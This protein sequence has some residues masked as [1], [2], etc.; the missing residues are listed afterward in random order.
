MRSGYKGSGVVIAS[1][2]NNTS[3]HGGNG[4]DIMK[5]IAPEADILYG[6]D[7]TR[8]IPVQNNQD[9]DV[10][11]YYDE[12]D[13]YTTARFSNDDYP[14]KVE[15][16][17]ELYNQ[18]VFLVCA[19]GNDGTEEARKLSQYKHWT[20]VGACIL[21]D[22]KPKRVYYSS[23]SEELDFMCL[24]NIETTSGRKF[25]GSSC[26]SFVF[27]AMIGLVQNFFIKN[28]G[29]KLTNE[30]LIEFI[31]DNCIDLEEEGF[32]NGTGNG[33]F[34]LPDPKEIN[35]K[36]YIDIETEEIEM[37]NKKMRYKT[38]KEVPAGEFHDTIKKLVDEGIIKGYSGSG[39]DT[40]V[41]LSEDM[42]RMFV[43]NN[44]AGVYKK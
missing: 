26:S 37:E 28:T 18:N 19:I 7:Y 23:E 35:I 16:A 12:V 2:E 40:V 11:Y 9:E 31:K 15:A 10:T 13:I 8:I 44:R 30:K 36:K 22:K 29:Q 33:L 14:Q 42:V 27:T 6:R 4:Y 25:G 34:V 41:D 5:Q 20:S 1:R 32:D 24:T 3:T 39:E 38:L 21:K 43:I 17:K